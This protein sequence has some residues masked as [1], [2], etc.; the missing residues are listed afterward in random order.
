MVSWQGLRW[1]GALRAWYRDQGRHQ[2]RPEPQHLDE[3]Q[4]RDRAEQFNQRPD[5]WHQEGRLVLESGYHS[6]TR[7]RHLYWNVSLPFFLDNIGYLLIIR[8]VIVLKELEW[9]GIRHSGSRME[10]LSRLALKELVQ[11]QTRL[12]SGSLMP[13]SS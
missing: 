11:S 10:M 2:R 12:N 13:R 5:I 1:M 8:L 9:V 7:R 3:A 4:W 6:G